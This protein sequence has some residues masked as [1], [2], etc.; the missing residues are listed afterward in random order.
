MFEE[1]AVSSEFGVFDHYMLLMP[2]SVRYAASSLRLLARIRDH[3]KATEF[4]EHHGSKRF[5]LYIRPTPMPY[6]REAANKI[7]RIELRL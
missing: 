6:L 5:L 7:V 3:R 4:A 1:A 2:H